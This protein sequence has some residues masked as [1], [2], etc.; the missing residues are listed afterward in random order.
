MKAFDYLATVCSLNLDRSLN[1]DISVRKRVILWFCPTVTSLVIVRVNFPIKC[2]H[3]V[4]QGFSCAGTS[5]SKHSPHGSLLL[6]AAK[7]TI[8]KQK[9]VWELPTSYHQLFRTCQA[10]IQRSTLPA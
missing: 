9:A 6:P 3:T 2:Y 5:W 8:A 10:A 4:D 7:C 1:H